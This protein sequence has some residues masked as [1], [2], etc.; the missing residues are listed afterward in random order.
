MAS[1]SSTLIE[2]LPN[3]WRLRVNVQLLPLVVE[4][5]KSL[6][7]IASISSTV[8]EHSPDHCKVKGSC[9]AT[10]T[11]NRKENKFNELD[12]H[13]WHSDKTLT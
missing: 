3:H 1:D 9:P 4:G 13:Q 2:H 11:G 12:Q 6:M 7:S 5:Q 10:A 8:T